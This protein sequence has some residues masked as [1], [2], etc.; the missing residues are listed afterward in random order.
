MLPRVSEALDYEGE[1]VI[2]VGTRSK[3]LDAEFA[4]LAIFG[5]C[6]GNDISVRDWQSK[7]TQVT[8][9]KSFDTSAPVGPWI[10]TSDEIGPHALIRTFV[11]GEQR[12]NSRTSKLVFNSYDQISHLSNAI[13]L[14]PG[15][16]DFT[17]T[18]GGGG[19]GAGFTP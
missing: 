4:K 9:G 14:E 1:M 8:L 2:V 12:Q 18:P 15:D 13:T 7:T 19:G 16:L 10:V 3:Y 11:N 5:F 6:V 17:S